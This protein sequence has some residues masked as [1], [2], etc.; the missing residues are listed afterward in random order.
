MKRL[1]DLFF[2]DIQ[3]NQGLAN[4]YQ[5]QPSGSADKPLPWPCVFW[6]SQWPHLVIIE[7]LLTIKNFVLHSAAEFLSE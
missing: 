3:N 5:P 2:C 7:C 1:L 6:I 4:G